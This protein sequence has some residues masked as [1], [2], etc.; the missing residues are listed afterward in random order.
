M[1]RE[2][3]NIV[4]EICEKDTRYAE[5]VYEFVME[6]LSYTQR[7]FNRSRHVTGPELLEGSRQ[8]LLKKFG[9]MA[10][11]VLKHWGVKRTEDFGNVVFNLVER[12]VLSKTEEDTAEDF[13]NGYD[14]D[15]V[16]RKHYKRILERQISRLR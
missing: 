8:L 2:F 5:G 12:K 13:K 7:T 9:P 16:F 3:D 11:T 4:T 15:E 6:A 1:N 10:L 14:F